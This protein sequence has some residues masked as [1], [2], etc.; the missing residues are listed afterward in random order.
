VATGQVGGEVLENTWIS[1]ATSEV[2]DDSNGEWVAANAGEMLTEQV[3]SSSDVAYSR[4]AHD[5]DV[6]A[7]PIHLAAVGRTRAAVGKGV[8]IG[9]GDRELR[10]SLYREAER[11]HRVV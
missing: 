2:D 7:F 1:R 4:R 8:E 10:I 9:D 11:R 6:M 3:G 5:L